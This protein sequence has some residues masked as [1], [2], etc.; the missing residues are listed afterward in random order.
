MFCIVTSAFI[1]KATE[2]FNDLSGWIVFCFYGWLITVSLLVY[3]FSWRQFIASFLYGYILWVGIAII[4]SIGML[5]GIRVL[6]M[7][8]S[9]DL[10]KLFGTISLG[11]SFLF[12]PFLVY[13]RKLPFTKLLPSLVDKYAKRR[14]DMKITISILLLFFFIASPCIGEVDK[15]FYLSYSKEFPGHANIASIEKDKEIFGVVTFSILSNNLKHPVD[16]KSAIYYAI[17][18]DDSYY[19][20]KF[21]K[22]VNKNGAGET[23]ILNPG[24]TIDIQCQTPYV[25]GNFPYA[26]YIEFRN[27]ERI[28]FILAGAVDYYS[29][30]W[31]RMLKK[32]HD[33]FR[34]H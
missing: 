9:N 28:Y 23:M 3:K 22:I 2:N 11:V 25:Y 8:F 18:R 24:E 29:T 4:V 13:S 21:L 7:R 20:C 1:A 31:A 33:L 17:A 10:I 16:F 30:W 15:Y 32:C 12:T 19:I 27:G 5:V 34:K 14:N 6:G 26:F